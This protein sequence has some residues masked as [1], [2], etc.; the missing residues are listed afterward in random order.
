MC[1]SRSL[2]T[3]IA[4]VIRRALVVVGVPIAMKSCQ[5]SDS[6]LVHVDGNRSLSEM[7]PKT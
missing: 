2:K 7:F 3:E 5:N 1:C 4:L 6:S